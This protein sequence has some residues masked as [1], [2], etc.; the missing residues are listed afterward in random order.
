VS[1]GEC[2]SVKERNDG[3]VHYSIFT[4]F[5]YIIL[6][7][8]KIDFK[9]FTNYLL[10]SEL[11]RN[12]SILISGTV[13]AQLLSILLQPFLRRFFSPESFGTY[14]V[15]LSLISIV[16]VISSFRFDDAIVLPKNDKDSVNVLSLAL[17]FNFLFNLFLFFIVILFGDKIILFLNLPKNFPVPVLYII[18]LGAFLYNTYL[19]LN[20]WLIRKQKFYIVSVNKLLRRVAEGISQ[21]SFAFAKLPNAL[22]YSDI[23]GQSVNV[24]TVIIQTFKNGLTFKVVSFTKLKYVLHKYSNFP[25]FNLI[26]AFMSTCSFMLPPIFINKFF[27]SESAGFFDL[28]KLLLSVPLALVATSFSS[29]LL[30]RVSEKYNR[31]ESFLSE[32]KPVFTI[33]CLISVIEIFSIILFGEGLFK[34]IFGNTWIFSGTISRILVWSFTFN[35]VVS[36]FTS[37]FVSMRKIKTYS[38]YQLFYFIAILSLLFFKNLDFIDF[39]KIYVII[40]VICYFILT[41]VI[42]LIITRYELSVRTNHPG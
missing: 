19:C 31:K 12:A 15:Y 37:I 20:Y 10:R 25:K 18:P 26:P 5:Q 6:P 7:P 41:S 38:L 34:F 33:V 17:I 13:I 4:L 40:E 11:L 35:F 21:V 2:P 30:Q 24:L 39:L 1:T 22:I 9:F 16:T 3:V 42:I 14:S 29:V 23:I 32:L 36:T 28:A 8:L 27:S